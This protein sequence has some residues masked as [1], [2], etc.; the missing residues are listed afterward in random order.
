MNRRVL[1]LL[2]VLCLVACA[3]TP[4]EPCPLGNQQAVVDSITSDTIW[5]ST[6]YCLRDGPLWP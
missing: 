1:A 2:A 5:V 6:G 4:A 3:T